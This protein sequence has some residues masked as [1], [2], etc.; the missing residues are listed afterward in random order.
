MFLQVSIAGKVHI[1]SPRVPIRNTMSGEVRWGS[2]LEH[3]HPGPNSAQIPWVDDPE[4][5]IG[6]RQIGKPEDMLGAEGKLGEH[7][8]RFEKILDLGKNVVVYALLNP[9][10]QIRM[11]YGFEQDAVEP[12]T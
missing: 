4:R 12:G 3:M 11:A 1:R 7:R 5:G 10:K 9:D 6:G 2:K 8:F